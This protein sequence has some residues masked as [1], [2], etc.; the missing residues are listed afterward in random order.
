MKQHLQ[1]RVYHS[2]DCDTDHSLIASG[3]KL[4]PK[5]LH[6]SKQKGQ[7]RINTSKTAYQV[8]HQEYVERFEETLAT[9]QEQSAS[10]RWSSLRIT[11]YS[12]AVSVNSKKERK[13]ADWF[14]ANITELEPVINGKRTALIKYKRGPT[15]KNIQALRAAGGRPSEQPAG[16][17]TTTGSNFQRASSKPQTRPTSEACMKA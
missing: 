5:K 12:T 1:T 2:A 17:P 10:N 4:T 8:K 6:H 14:E 11:I 3:V 7:P 9:S 15:P 16:A 13:N